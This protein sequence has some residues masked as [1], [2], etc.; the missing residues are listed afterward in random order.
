[1]KL[2]SFNIGIKIDNAKN[3]GNFIKDQD[4]DIVAFQ[5]IIRH[6]DDSVFEMYKSK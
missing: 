3:V 6:F 4:P 2:I 1:M 5:E